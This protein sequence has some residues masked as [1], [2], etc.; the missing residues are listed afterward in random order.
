MRLRALFMP[1]GVFAAAALK[2]GPNFQPKGNLPPGAPNF[3]AIVAGKLYMD[4]GP[5]RRRILPVLA[6]TSSRGSLRALPRELAN[7]YWQSR[8]PECGIT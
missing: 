3:Y 6:A 1:P 2:A 5:V 8:S 7:M 4:E